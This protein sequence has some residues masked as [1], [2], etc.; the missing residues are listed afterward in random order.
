MFLLN[1]FPLFVPFHPFLRFTHFVILYALLISSF[2]ALY[3]F[4]CSPCCIH[5]VLLSLPFLCCIYFA[6]LGAILLCPLFSQ[7]R[8]S[9][10][11]VLL[12]ALSNWP[13]CVVPYFSLL[14]L[15]H[16]LLYFT[17]ISFRLPFAF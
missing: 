2:S 8:P 11:F 15:F 4:C 14:Y 17:C 1:F 13:F 6:L 16:P 3:L 10:Y 12:I 7:F 5:F 9:Q